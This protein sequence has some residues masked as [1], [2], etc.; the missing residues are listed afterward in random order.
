MVTI[1][2]MKVIDFNYR[3][4]NRIKER[5]HFYSILFIISC[6]LHLLALNYIFDNRGEQNTCVSFEL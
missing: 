2:L 5:E 6:T 4:E 3:G 1:L